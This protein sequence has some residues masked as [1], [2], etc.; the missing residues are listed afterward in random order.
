MSNSTIKKKK[1]KHDE[2]VVL[3]KLKLN[4]MVGVI[5]KSLR[6]SNISHDEFALINNVLKNSDEIKEEIKNLKTNSLSNILVFLSNN[7]MVLLEL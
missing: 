1:R 6:G 4:R 2:I 5:S 7:V 3:S